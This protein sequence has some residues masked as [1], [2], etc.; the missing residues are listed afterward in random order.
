MLS[1]KNMVEF[2]RTLAGGNGLHKEDAIW[3][4]SHWTGTGDF[5][6]LNGV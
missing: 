4:G 1:T 6:R 3:N 5:S 2:L